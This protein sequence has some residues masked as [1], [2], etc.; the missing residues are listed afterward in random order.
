MYINHKVA[1]SC[2]IWH[3]LNQPQMTDFVINI[4]CLCK[5]FTEHFYCETLMK[6]ILQEL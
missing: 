2:H 5:H 1:A 6:S 3:A 4:S